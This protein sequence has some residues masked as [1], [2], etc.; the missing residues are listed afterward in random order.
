MAKLNSEDWRLLRDQYGVYSGLPD[1]LFEILLEKIFYHVK[2]N[3]GDVDEVD[4]LMIRLSRA[5]PPIRP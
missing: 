1:E 5:E 3:P 4:A 2:S